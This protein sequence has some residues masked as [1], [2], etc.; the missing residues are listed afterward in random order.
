MMLHALF[1]TTF[2]LGKSINRG[3]RTFFVPYT[4]KTAVWHLNS[5]VL[6]MLFASFFHPLVFFLLSYT[7]GTQKEDGPPHHTG[8]NAN[9]VPTQR[10]IWPEHP[11]VKDSFWD[12]ALNE[13]VEANS[14]FEYWSSDSFG[15]GTPLNHQVYQT[16]FYD[17]D[18][19]EGS[20]IPPKSVLRMRVKREEVPC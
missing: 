12:E 19:G 4:F 2:I 5:L 13:R 15:S 8:S 16:L 1:A 3:F 11:V 17:N 14:T 9:P 20:A 10:H 6:S 18:D 7:H